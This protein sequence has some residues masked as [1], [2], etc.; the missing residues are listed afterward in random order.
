M[1]LLL[2]GN[3]HLAALRH[4]LRRFP[5]R[6]PALEEADFFG[7]PGDGLRQLELRDGVLYPRDKEQEGQ[8]IFYNG[9]PDLP[10]SGYDRVIVVG[11]VKFNNALWVTAGLR[12][13]L[14]PMPDDRTL[15]SRVL[16]RAALDHAVASSMAAGLLRRL[17]PMASVS[18]LAEPFASEE[19][20]GQPAAQPG[21]AACNARG[22]LALMAE[23]FNL[24]LLR[25]LGCPVISQPAQTLAGPG[26]TLTQF[27][28]GSLRLNPRQ[29]VPHENDVVHGNAAY[30]AEVMDQIE[31]L[32]SA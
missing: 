11:G 12:C 31:A 18:Y 17:A 30:G 4:A 15:V 20:L 14:N 16:W 24:A 19:A 23:E 28:H 25:Q 29:D 10:I 21:I 26:L 22:E 2:I 9:V 3:S 5:D 1:S 8:A 27:M 7:L 6:W 32:L 13:V